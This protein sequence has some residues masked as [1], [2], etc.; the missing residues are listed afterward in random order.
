MQEVTLWSSHPIAKCNFQALITQ[1]YEF[2]CF[3]F[4]F[5]FPQPASHKCKRKRKA[6]WGRNANIIGKFSLKQSEG[7]ILNYGPVTEKELVDYPR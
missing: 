2:A 5:F 7:R 1:P 6:V 3:L 4:H